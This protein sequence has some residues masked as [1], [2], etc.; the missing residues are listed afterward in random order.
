MS[1]L[2][3][4]NSLWVKVFQICRQMGDPD[5]LLVVDYLTGITPEERERLDAYKNAQEDR[6]ILDHSTSTPHSSSVSNRRL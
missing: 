5:D 2:D 3:Q 4:Y 1:N 6:A